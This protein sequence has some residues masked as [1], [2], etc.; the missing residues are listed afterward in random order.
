MVEYA[1]L[2]AL[3]AMVAFAGISILGVN[4]QTLYTSVAG[5]V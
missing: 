2:I 3:I 5:S 1:L 4:L